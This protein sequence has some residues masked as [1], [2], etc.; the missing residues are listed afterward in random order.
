VRANQLLSAGTPAFESRQR[1]CHHF[2]SRPGP[3]PDLAE[4]VRIFNELIGVFVVVG[5]DVVRSHTAWPWECVGS[6]AQNRSLLGNS[7]NAV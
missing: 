5:A 2:G 4:A 1:G 3:R 6:S 7:V